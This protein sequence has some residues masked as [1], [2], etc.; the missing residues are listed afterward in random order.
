LTM[1]EV[2]AMEGARAPE[3]RPYWIRYI[4]AF[5]AGDKLKWVRDN[6]LVACFCSIARLV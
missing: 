4:V 6:V 1:E 5:W 2:R 3:F